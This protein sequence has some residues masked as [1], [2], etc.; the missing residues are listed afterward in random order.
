MYVVKK[1]ITYYKNQIQKTKAAPYLVIPLVLIFCFSAIAGIAADAA[2]LK[3]ITV[4]SD[5]N[6]PPFIFR[7]EKGH[8]QGIL[9]DEWRLWEEKTGIKVDLRGMDWDKAQKMM[10]EGKAHVIDTMFFTEKRAKTLTFSA[11]YASIDV[12]IF[13]HKDIS[14]IKDVKSLYGFTIGVKAGDACIDFLKRH[15][16]H[17]LREYPSY[18]SIVRDAAEQKIK[19]F[20]IDSPPAHY[21]L[22]KMNLEQQY[23]YTA[24][25]YTGQFHRAVQKERKDLLT[26]VEDGFAKISRKEHK[27]IE[28]R[29]RGSPIAGPYLTYLFYLIGVFV[30][31]GAILLLWN[32]TLRRKVT[33]KTVQLQEAFKDLEKSEELFRSYLEYA[34]DGVYMSDVK[35]NLIYGNR[36]VEEIIGYRREDLIGKNFLELNLLTEKGLNKAVQ[37]LQE[38]VKGN[39]TGPDE[40]ELINKE[41]RLIPVEISTSVVQRMG[42]GIVLGFVRDITDRK[43]AEDSLLQSEG[44]YRTILE[45]IQEGYFEVDFAG[46]FTFFNNSLCR[47]LGYSKEEL[48]GMNNRQ[49]TDKEHSKKLFQAFNKVYYSGEPTEGFDWQIIRKDGTKRYVE[50]SVSLQKD[51]SGTP[52]GFRGIARDVTERKKVEEALR[53]SENRLRA[54]Y[55]GNPI[56]TYTWQK[57]G[58]EFILKDFNDSANTLTSGQGKTFLGRQA[59]EMYKSRQEMLGTLQKCFDEKRIIRVESISEHFMPGKFVVITFVFVPPD[60]VMVHMEDITERKKSE[61]TIKKSEAKYRNIF[62]NAIEG[63][64]QSTIEGRFITANAALARMA[65][66]D[67]PE[68]LIES[69]KDIGTQL[70]VNSEDRKRFMEIREAKGFVSGFE[71]EFYKKDG[72]KFWVVINARTVKDEQGEILYIEGLIE[73]ISIRKHAE[74]LLHQTLDSLRKAVSTT[75]QVLVS[76]VEMK[77]PYTA[78]HQLRVADLARA[79]ATEMKLSYDKIEG[80]RMAGSIHDIGKLSIPAEILSKPTKLTNIE[81]S[82]I[83][84]HPQTGYEMLKDVE[85]PWPLAEIVYQHHE[86]MNGSGY[87]RNLKGD[88]IILDARI[89]A[90]ADVVEAMGSHRPYRPTLGIE[91]ALEEIEKNKGIL[92]DDTV[93][94]ACLKLFREKG[95][96]LT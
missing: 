56:P 24:P 82:L 74:E 80:I 45:D 23:R 17:T 68:E 37:W 33:K 10:A 71:V 25:L 40:I 91:A 87:P 26:V 64:Y 79:I 62:E 54:Q 88:E 96:Q 48:M 35:G 69:I 14:G 1:L 7:D 92:Y 60:L 31:L 13:F 29:W 11:P 28:K 73:D 41:G 39:P 58:D 4:V 66:Y 65:G 59:S 19:V 38:N 8:L 44:K 6:Y 46:N 85:S 57:Q 89:M 78:G 55:N 77:D 53:E 67:S 16:I 27:E 51:S 15:G 32:H 49:Y 47:F 43:R 81:F 76:A 84:E 75:I 18:E 22:S 72:S 21:F 93:A 50:A 30:F 12:P 86:R 42:Q 70:Y 83:K 9:V 36:K 61:E 52:T 20:C 5:D 90:V 95:F 94:D 34:P 2:P 3:E 63:I